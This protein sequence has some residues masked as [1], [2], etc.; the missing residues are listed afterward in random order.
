MA[1]SKGGVIMVGEQFQESVQLR[2]D[3]RTALERLCLDQ[4]ELFKGAE[5]LP[6]ILPQELATVSGWPKRRVTAYLKELEEQGVLNCHF[7]AS[8][9]KSNTGEKCA[10]SIRWVKYYELF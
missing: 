4:E 8:L 3:V 10:Y 2:R 5:E 1:D 7:L 9:G 6:G